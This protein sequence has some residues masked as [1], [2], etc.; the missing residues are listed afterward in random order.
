MV[1]EPVGTAVQFRV[2]DLTTAA[3]DRG[4]IRHGVDGVLEEIRDVVSHSA[5][6]EHVIVLGNGPWRYGWLN[7]THWWNNADTRSW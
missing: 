6:V 3:H 4:A 5:K 7:R 1:G 2:G